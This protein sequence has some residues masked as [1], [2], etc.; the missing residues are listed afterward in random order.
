MFPGKIIMERASLYLAKLI[1][2]GMTQEEIAK[3]LDLSQNAIHKYLNGGN[4]RKA[5]LDRLIK[6]FPQAKAFIYDSSDEMNLIVNESSADYLMSIP[7][8]HAYASYTNNWDD[9]E[10]IGDLPKYI[11]TKKEDGRYRAFEVRSESMEYEGDLS[12][13]EG[14]IVVGKEL[15]RHHW[16]NKLHIP[17]VFIIHHK[18]KG[19]MIK[20]IIRH[21]TT[22]ARITC[23]SFNTLYPDFDLELNDVLELYYCKEVKTNRFA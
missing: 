5:N 6:E 2:D 13:H 19:I 4:F 14:D 15:Q 12:L 3:K 11:T 16:S 1:K 18:D 9:Q 21:D 8:V 17:R 7:L 22:R 20:Q 23:H 10:W